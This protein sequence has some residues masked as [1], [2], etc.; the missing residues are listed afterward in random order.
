MKIELR[1]ANQQ[2]VAQAAEECARFMEKL[3]SHYGDAKYG[4]KMA[5]MEYVLFSKG[6]T[7]RQ[8]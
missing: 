2:E 8:D 4:T 1:Q 7:F 3:G 6:L 5:V